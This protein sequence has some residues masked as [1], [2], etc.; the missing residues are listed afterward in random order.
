MS[1]L[2]VMRQ[3]GSFVIRHRFATQDLSLVA[4]A[5][6][7]VAYVLYE[8]DVFV[9]GNDPLRNVLEFDELPLLGAVLCVG[10]LI[11][12]WRR[13]RE[14]NRETKRRIVAE[15]NARSLAM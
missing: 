1:I 3:A 15:Q 4:L 12:S 9:T 2:N 8:F 5:S 6:A 11:F 10:L 14:Q 13:S 7:V